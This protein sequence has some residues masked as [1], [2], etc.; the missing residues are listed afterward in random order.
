M[1]STDTPRPVT[2]ELCEWISSLSLSDIPTEKVTRVKYLI[3]DGLACALIAAR[4]PWSEAA[5]KGVL[6][7]ESS[8]RCGI[9]G[10]DKKTGPL[11][12]ALL[13]STF[14]QGFELDDYH[15]GAPIHSSSIVLPTLLAAVEHC[16]VSTDEQP[17]VGGAEFLLAAIVGYETGPRVGLGVYGIE[18]LTHGW[19]SG[20]IF[21]PAASAATAAK[22]FQLPASTIEDAIG[23]ACTQAGGLMSAQYE[24]T[25]KRMQHGFAT[26]NGLF[27]AFMARNGYTGIKQVLERPYGGFLSNFSL[28]NGRTPAY[29]PGEV[30]N[31]L[32]ERWE[33]DRIVVKPYASVA[34]THSTIDALMALQTRYPTQMAAVHQIRRIRVE[35]SE[36]SFKKCGW[37]PRRPLTPTGAQMSATYAAA[38]QLLEGEVQA[39]QF[40]PAQL[41]RDDLW[42]LMDRIHCEQNMELESFQ[43]RVH[44]EL[45]GQAAPLTE[46]VTAPRGNGVPLSNQD[47]LDK[48]RRLTADVIDSERQ[49]AIERIVLQL[50]TVQDVRQLARLLSGRTGNIFEAGYKTKL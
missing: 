23:I 3:L 12:A 10:W 19:H 31:G 41:E 1:E 13:N 32:G 8:G 25:A 17:L 42:S 47:I 46:F 9:I 6:T 48:W 21:G 16:D 29:V 7:M 36:V 4:L 14:I 37:T 44:V 11:A 15:S 24:S 49:A 5:V 18:V 34:T 28:G 26:R 45:D 43:Q 2:R 35:M 40:A 30:V 50:E 22:L 27:A 20:A 33:I 39:A 38:M